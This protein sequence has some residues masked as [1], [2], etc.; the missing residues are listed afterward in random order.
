MPSLCGTFG[1]YFRSLKRLRS[2]GTII[3]AKKKGLRSAALLVVISEVANGC[4]VRAVIY[5]PR[6]LPA[7]SGGVCS[8]HFR[9]LASLCG[10]LGGLVQ[11]SS[12][13]YVKPLLLRVGKNSACSRSVWGVTQ[14]SLKRLRS[15]T[16]IFRA[17][18]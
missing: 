7:S 15:E 11:K 2:E 17:K 12:P 9:E 8:G 6:R 10:R 3:R 5:A 16:T 13:V 1:V 18:K 14:I 4:G